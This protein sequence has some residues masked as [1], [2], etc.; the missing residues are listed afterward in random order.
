MRDYYDIHVLTSIYKDSINTIILKNALIN[1]CNKRK[2]TSLIENSEKIITTIS[3]S[4][5]VQK[6]WLAYSKKYFYARDY[7]FDSVIQSIEKLLKSM[8]E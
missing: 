2:S 5:D 8:I 3:K 7:D 6:L 1:T 4:E